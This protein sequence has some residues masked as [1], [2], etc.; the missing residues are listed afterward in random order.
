MSG[1]ALHRRSFFGFIISLSLLEKSY[2]AT[3]YC[4]DDRDDLFG[5]AT[6]AKTRNAIAKIREH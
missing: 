4:Y 3:D 5:E 6:L 2:G 1:G